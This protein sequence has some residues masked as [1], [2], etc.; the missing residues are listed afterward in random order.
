MNKVLH[1]SS[2]A[3]T[4]DLPTESLIEHILTRFHDVHREQLPE[5]IR[6][7]ERV[8]RVHGGHPLCPSGLTGQLQDMQAEL[9]S[10]MAKEEQILFPMIARGIQGMAAGPVS[11]MR[12][13]HDDHGQ[14][15]EAIL[16]TTDKLSIP[17]DA[18]KTWQALYEGIKTFRDD[19][20]AHIQLEN[21][22]LFTRVDG[23]LG[24]A[25]HG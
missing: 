2:R 1:S 15:L 18:C 12:H 21:N 4:E 25:S 9:E 19:L 7:S 8:E 13:E 22:V 3:A 11:V 6:L 16:G 17:E 14:A 24:G 10:H 23:G 20:L 5:L